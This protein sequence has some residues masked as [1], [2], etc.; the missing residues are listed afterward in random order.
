MLHSALFFLFFFF[1]LLLRRIGFNSPFLFDRE[2]NTGEAIDAVLEEIKQ[3]I[4]KREITSNVVNIDMISSIVADLTSN[5]DDLNKDSLQLYDAFHTPKLSFDERTRHYFMDLKQNGKY[6]LFPR[7]ESRSAMYRERLL[8]A[9][10]RLLRNTTLRLQSL[11]GRPD[12]DDAIEISTVES[13]LGSFGHE[14]VLFG[15]ITQVMFIV[16]GRNLS[17][18]Y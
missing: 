16:F 4:E 18:I 5:D 1:C 12:S 7:L 8:L 6:S 11:G 10:Q 17:I 3:R 9:Q 15:I 14:R 13:L 2:E